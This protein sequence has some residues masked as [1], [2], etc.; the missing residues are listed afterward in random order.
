[1]CARITS[2]SAES[3]SDSKQSTV[4]PRSFTREATCFLNRFISASGLSP[5]GSA[6]PAMGTYNASKRNRDPSATPAEITS[7]QIT[8]SLIV[9]RVLFTV[10]VAPITDVSC[11]I[12]YN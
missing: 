2:A 9:S 10:G 11:R 3:D 12:I 5:E 7:Q 8:D 1:M 6:V 4:S